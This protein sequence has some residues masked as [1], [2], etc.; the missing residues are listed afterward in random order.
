MENRTIKLYIHPTPLQITNDNGVGKVVHAQHQYLGELGFQ[1]V[2]DPADADVIAAHITGDHLPRIDALHLHGVYY[3]ADKL[4]QFREEHSALNFQIAESCRRARRITIPSQWAGEFLRRDMRIKPVTIPN[5]VNTGEWTGDVTN[6]GYVLWNKNRADDVCDPTPA[7]ELAN[8]GLAVISTFAPKNKPIPANMQ[9]VG[10]RPFEEMKGLIGYAGCYLATTK[11]VMSLSV[12]E[13][14]AAGVPVLGYSWGGT[15]D[16]VEHRVTGYLVQPGDIDGLME[17]YRWIQENREE[18]K[19]NC[20]AAAARYEWRAI[21]ERY[22]ELY[23]EVLAEREAEQFRVAVIIP[24]Y[25]YVKWVEKAIES[26][27]NQTYKPDEIIVVDDASTD[28]SLGTIQSAAT[29]VGAKVI[30]QPA[31]MGVAHARNAGIKATGCELIVCLDADD[32]LEPTY[33][34]TLRAGFAADHSLGVAWSK[35][36][37]IREDGTDTGQSWDFDFKWEDQASADKF[38]NGIP[39]GAMFRRTMWERSGGYKQVYHPAEDAEFWLRGLSTGFNARRVTD[40]LLFNYRTHEGSATL[41]RPR[42]YIHAWHPWAKDGRYPFAAP[43]SAPSPTYSYSEPKVSVIIPVGPGH[44]GILYSA[45]DSL[46]GQTFREWEAIVVSDVHLEEREELARALIPY[47]FV[48]LIKP[49]EYQSGVG[50]GAARNIGI[51]AASAPTVL[52]LDADDYLFPTAIEKMLA[53]H[54]RT[55]GK[56]VYTDWLRLDPDGKTTPHETPEYSGN[57]WLDRGQHAVTVLMATADALK[58]G[59][60]DETLVGWEDWDF[61]IKAAIACICGVRVPEP[62]FGYRIATGTRRE[63]SLAN[64]DNL[65]SEIDARYGRYR[66]GEIVMACG[67]QQTVVPEIADPGDTPAGMVRLEFTGPEKGSLPFMVNG[68]TY[69]VADNDGERVIDVP[70]ADAPRFLSYGCFKAVQMAVV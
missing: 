37:L 34:E 4:G 48:R 22:A 7:L 14:L 23:R 36:R 13:A 59:G 15:A 44:S 16:V 12:L 67:C 39:A 35:L 56:Y 64:R 65:I 21:I 38:R 30:S 57:A 50:A 6:R 8:R 17:G 2:K 42:P 69:R 68:K 33:L 32:T 55:A 11:E 46:L 40:Q 25:N 3:T 24:N 63:S 49:F 9:L 43:A 28:A 60:F 41:T 10:L 70:A 27:A 52:F 66:R 51:K 29:R 61:F 45:L 31:N 53:A 54:K 1:F 18:L 19:L 62:L 47:P 5:G 20:R 26:A 58:I